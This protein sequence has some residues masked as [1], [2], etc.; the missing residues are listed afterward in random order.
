[1]NTDQLTWTLLKSEYL[2]NDTWFKARKDT[3]RKPDGKIVDPYYV[4][5][6]PTWAAAVAI[7]E[8]DKVVLVKQY[9][10]AIQQTIIELPGGCIDDTDNAIEDGIRREL[11]EETGYAFNDITYLGKTSP[12]PSTN[13]N[14]LHMYLLKG[15]VKVQEQ[16]LDHNEEIEVLLVPLNELVKMLQTNSFIQAMHVTTIFY[17]LQALGTL[18]LRS[19]GL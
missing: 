1:M 5:E 3:C 2:H 4:M 13:S 9:R 17:A 14:Y 18:H 6:Y 8:D 11:L 16:E 19:T 7:T 12:N 15:G 10:H